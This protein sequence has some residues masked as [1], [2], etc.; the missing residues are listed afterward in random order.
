MSVIKL[1]KKILEKYGF[2]ID[3]KKNKFVDFLMKL[4]EKKEEREFLFENKNNSELIS[5]KIKSINAETNNLFL[6]FEKVFFLINKYS[7]NK[8]QVDREIINELKNDFN[9]NETFSNFDNFFNK[10]KLFKD[11]L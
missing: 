11:K 6:G 8:Y 1:S 9:N 2:E 3:V 10:F 4:K 7:N 5:N